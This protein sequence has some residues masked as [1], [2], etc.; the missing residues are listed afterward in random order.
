MRINMQ[1][2]NILE[3][4]LNTKVPFRNFESVW[5]NLEKPS[6]LMSKQQ[7]LSWLLLYKI[8]STTMFSSLWYDI[9]IQM[10]DFITW[11]ISF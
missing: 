7:K 9:T 6:L 2:F 10:K 8:T 11:E 4:H 5:K 1:I 3:I